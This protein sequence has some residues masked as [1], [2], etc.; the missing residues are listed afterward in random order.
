LPVKRATDL[1]LFDAAAGALHRVKLAGQVLH[2]RGEELFLADQTSGFRATLAAENKL[3]PEVGD[4]VEVVGFPEL[5]GPSP[6]LREAVF[7]KTGQAALPPPSQLELSAAGSMGQYD[8]TRVVLECLVASASIEKDDQVIVAQSGAKGFIARL[9]SRG[10]RLPKLLPGSRIH[11]SGVY[12]SQ[13]HKGFR[14]ESDSFELLLNSPADVRVLQRPSWWTFERTMALVGGMAVVIVAALVWITLLRRK[15]EERSRQL[16]IAIR[17][18][19]QT[20]RQRELEGERARIARDLHDDLGA[21]LTQ[22]RFLSAVESRDS[23]LPEMSRGRLSQI[24]EKSRELVTSLDEIVWAVNP[25]NDSLTSLATYLCQSAEEFFRTTPIRCRLDVDDLLP[26]V[27]LSSEVR[28]NI[29]LAVREALNNAAKHSRAAE[30]WIRIQSRAE[31]LR[32]VVEDN[33]MGFDPVAVAR[34]E[35]SANMEARLAAIG[36]QFQCET[37]AGRGTRCYFELPLGMPQAGL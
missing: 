11:I 3:R 18:H 9:Q 33:G 23:S 30:I 26:S 20:E 1:L 4:L 12:A 21:S 28:H 15:V 29:Y 32:I 17:R 19:E 7:K 31:G 2:D 34:G 24:S 37:G 8:S 27:S 25:A 6:V 35:G 14:P 16:T 22:I 13:W 5:G 10:G 36:G